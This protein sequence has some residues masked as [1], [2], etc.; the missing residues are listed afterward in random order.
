[1]LIQ[2][3]TDR[4]GRTTG[5]V[6]HFRRAQLHVGRVQDPAPE[7]EAWQCCRICG[8]NVAQVY[9]RN[10]Q[11]WLCLDCIQAHEL[12]EGNAYVQVH[13]PPAGLHGLVS[14]QMHCEYLSRAAARALAG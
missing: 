5:I 3:L 4:T 10:H 14:A 6:L 12:M 13:P 2:R 8:T 9:C 1:M 11:I 7:P